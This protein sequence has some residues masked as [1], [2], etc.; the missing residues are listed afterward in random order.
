MLARYPINTL[1]EAHKKLLLLLLLAICN[2]NLI[3][4]K[5][6]KN[7]SVTHLMQQSF[8]NPLLYNRR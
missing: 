6:P 7:S 4:K 2:K 1:L 3:K 5:Y 8:T